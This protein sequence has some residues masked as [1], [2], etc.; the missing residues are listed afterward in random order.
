MTVIPNAA[1]FTTAKSIPAKM[2]ENALPVSLQV[3]L[4]ASV[5]GKTLIATIFAPGAT[6]VGPAMTPATSVP[7]PSQSM[8]SLSLSGDI[9]AADHLGVREAPASHARDRVVHAGVDDGDRLAGAGEAERVGLVAADQDLRAL[10]RRL[11]EMGLLVEIDPGDIRVVCQRDRGLPGG[12]AGEHREALVI[13]AHRELPRRHLVGQT[14]LRGHAQ[15]APFR[16][17]L[18]VGTGQEPPGRWGAVPDADDD[19]DFFDAAAQLSQEARSGV[20]SVGRRD[21]ADRAGGV[22]REQA[23]QENEN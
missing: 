11:E 5:E 10:R 22:R 4:V 8:G 18:R 9:N 15:D 14:F 20:G 17:S 12:G 7:C 23:Q 21:R 13:V 19:A 6:P 3:E 2:S 16:L 1:L